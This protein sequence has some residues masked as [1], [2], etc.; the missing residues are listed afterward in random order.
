MDQNYTEI[1]A[2]VDKSGSMEHLTK[3]T[4]GGINSFI[5]DQKALPGKANL[6]VLLFDNTPHYWQ[7][8][9]DVTKVKEF[10]E[11]DYKE[12]GMGGTALYDAIGFG[13]EELGSRLKG[14]KEEDRPGKVIIAILTD[15]GENASTKFS[16]E[17][18]QEMIKTQT[19]VY[20]WGI[21]YLAAGPEAFEAGQNIGLHLNNLVSFA[22]NAGNT[23]SAYS[24][25]S[26]SVKTLRASKKSGAEYAN[27]LNL[28]AAYTAEGGEADNV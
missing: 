1:L 25:I 2:I 9:A 10:T 4:V 18:I 21:L 5:S 16:L 24:T 23:K 19:E 28:T 12:G 26:R 11:K 7:S 13:F 14:M 20:S 17:K 22:N 8:A 15:G 6:S 3:D 27:E